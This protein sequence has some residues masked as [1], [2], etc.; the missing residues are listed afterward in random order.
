MK[1]GMD[2]GTTFSLPA[3]LINGTVATL[4]PCG[5]YGME[6]V[7]YYD[8]KAGMLVGKPAENRGQLKPNNIIRDICFYF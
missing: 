8:E 5:S 1:I 2:F 4:L 3:G 6:S 7:F